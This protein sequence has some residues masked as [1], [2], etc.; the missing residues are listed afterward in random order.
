MSS[1]RYRR[2]LLAIGGDGPPHRVVPVAARLALAGDAEVI[3]AHIREADERG[4]DSAHR[5]V[6][7]QVA[8][9]RRWG[10][11]AR[12]DVYRIRRVTAAEELSDLARVFSAELVA[13]G[14]HS[15]SRIG[16]IFSLG[17]AYQ[18]IALLR[19]PVLL[20][21]D[22]PESAEHPIASTPPEVRTVLVAL[23]V[24]PGSQPVLETA[25]A[26]G[27]ALGSAVAIVHVAPVVDDVHLRS[28]IEAGERAVREAHGRLEAAGLRV[29]EVIVAEPGGIGR[30]V[31]E[32]AERVDAG[33]IVVGSSR[34]AGRSGLALGSVAHDLPTLTA[35]PILFTERR[36]E[37]APG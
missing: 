14:F 9:L 2:I 37:S 12:G 23:D 8:R 36:R 16:A 7:E 22:Q 27:V 32:A 34:A 4:R 13:L 21:S 30:R 5:L 18:A 35:R 24:L 29:T 33:L 28:E 3:V 10:V 6:D 31:A 11:K 19:C 1:T 25:R 26:L 15:R 17:T 20:A